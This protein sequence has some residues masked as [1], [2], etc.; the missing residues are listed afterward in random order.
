MNGASQHACEVQLGKSHYLCFMQE[1]DRTLKHRQ[2]KALNFTP[3]L[4]K[5]YL[6]AKHS[7]VEHV[8]LQ[9][10]DICICR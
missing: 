1:Q 3:K 7:A 4:W 5:H 6:V 10:A 9:K 2:I 8:Y